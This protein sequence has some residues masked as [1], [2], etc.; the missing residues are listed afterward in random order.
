MDM[1]LESCRT[2]VEVLASNA[3]APGGH[4]GQF[5]PVLMRMRRDHRRGFAV[6]A[7]DLNHIQIPEFQR[8]RDIGV[9]KMV[10]CFFI[11]HLC[12]SHVYY[13]PPRVICQ[14]PGMKK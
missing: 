8:R 2:F 6:S 11:K 10:S 1:T 9:V 4:D 3:P 12:P 5:E 7:S 14:E 13:N